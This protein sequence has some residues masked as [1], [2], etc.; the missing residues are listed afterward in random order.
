MDNFPYPLRISGQQVFA[1]RPGA[2]DR[3]QRNAVTYAVDDID[4]HLDRSLVLLRI[5]GV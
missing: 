1:Q 2:E 4:R 5:E 3:A